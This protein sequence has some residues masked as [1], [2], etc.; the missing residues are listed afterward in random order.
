MIRDQWL[1]YALL[2][3]YGNQRLNDLLGRKPTRWEMS[4]FCAAIQY[5]LNREFSP[6]EQE[7]NSN[8]SEE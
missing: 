1:N 7:T 4:L 6:K 5:W 2:C 3:R 8:N